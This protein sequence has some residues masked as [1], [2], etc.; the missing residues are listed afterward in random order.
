MV[1]VDSVSDLPSYASE[2]DA[3]HRAHLVEFQQI[4]QDLPISRG[5][6]VLDLACGDGLY[7][8]LLAHRVG[9]KGTIIAADSSKN[10]LDLANRKNVCS[11]RENLQFLA[12]EVESLPFSDGI[13]D[14]VWCAHSLVSFSKPAFA[15]IQMTRILRPGGW[16]A[17]M[18]ND[19]LHEVILPWPPELELAIRQAELDAYR[20]QTRRPNKRYIARELQS[21]FI[22]A[23]LVHVYRRTYS[24]DRSWPIDRPEH[25]YLCRYL[26]RLRD[27]VW[28]YLSHQHRF[29]F[30][31][32]SDPSSTS[33]LAAQPGFG[34]TWFE[35]V[36]YGQKATEPN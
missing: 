12:A 3:R 33:F 2:L 5:H 7:A 15:L 21:G 11:D 31:Q 29:Q 32:I 13:F 27:L 30:E 14:L 22:N 16:V 28:P 25:E 8:E 23:G 9:S 17:V 36:C 35:V 6:C 4:I 34:M 10:Y 19:S 1:T 18:E 20:D 26:V 24:I